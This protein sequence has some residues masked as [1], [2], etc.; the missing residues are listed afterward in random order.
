MKVKRD[1]PSF[2]G[3]LSWL[4]ET[5]KNTPINLRKL[6]RVILNFFML[7]AD[8]YYSMKYENSWTTTEEKVFCTTMFWGVT[9][10]V[11][12]FVVG[13]PLAFIIKLPAGVTVSTLFLL[14]FLFM[15]WLEYAT[16][17]EKTH[18]S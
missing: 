3:W 7:V 13:L 2:V 6:P 18:E 12:F 14:S 8:V 17:F 16:Q 11:L 4:T 9:W 5:T 1:Q 10:G 15:S